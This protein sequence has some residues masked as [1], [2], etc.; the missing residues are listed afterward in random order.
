M[1]SNRKLTLKCDYKQ[2]GYVNEAAIL[3]GILARGIHQNDIVSLQIT[4]KDVYIKFANIE[5]L[6]IAKTTFWLEMD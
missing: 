6:T 2:T 1:S 4:R 5:A 3:D